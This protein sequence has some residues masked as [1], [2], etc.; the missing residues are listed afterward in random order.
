MEERITARCLALDALEGLGDDA[1]ARRKA[2]IKELDELSAKMQGLGL[3]S[4]GLR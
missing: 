3:L 1:R 2:L 4:P